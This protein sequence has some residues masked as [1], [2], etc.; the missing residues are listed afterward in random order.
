[1]KNVFRRPCVS[2]PRMSGPL[3]IDASHLHSYSPK[4][5]P[6]RVSRVPGACNSCV[7]NSHDSSIDRTG[8]TARHGAPR[9][10]HR[11]FLP[12]IPDRRVNE[13][14]AVGAGQ[15]NYARFPP[16]ISSRSANGRPLAM[17]IV[18]RERARRSRPRRTC[19]L[20]F[21]SSE[22]LRC[23]RTAR[24]RLSPTIVTNADNIFHAASIQSANMRGARRIS[25][26]KLD[27]WFLFVNASAAAHLLLE[28]D[29]QYLRYEESMYVISDTT[30][31]IRKTSI[32][33]PGVYP[34]DIG[35][36]KW[37]ANVDLSV[38][39]LFACSRQHG[40][41]VSLARV[42]NYCDPGRRPKR[43]GCHP[44][45]LVQVVGRFAR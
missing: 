40:S 33:P 13:I 41:P 1:M 44:G 36:V 2:Y 43:G 8:R 25:W 24:G 4:M 21:L 38:V 18:R 42:L 22:D 11:F 10:P 35:R 29:L 14:D 19:S 34:Y 30:R 6:K 39:F 32:A 20:F 28:L 37:Y 5:L 9:H 17:G 26:F 16:R 12:L 7:L 3:G 23:I 31:Y 27:T 15:V 45:Y